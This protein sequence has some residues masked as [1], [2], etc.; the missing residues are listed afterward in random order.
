M[1]LFFSGRGSNLEAILTRYHQTWAKPPIVVTNNPEA[2]GI[3]VAR[4]FNIEPLILESPINYA[5]LSQYLRAEGVECIFLLGYLKII[6]S[7]FIKTWTNRIFNLHPSL[8][9]FYPGLRSI[10]R[11]YS[12]RNDIGVT[13][14][15][16]TEGVDE[17]QVMVQQMVISSKA[18][19]KDYIS[20]SQISSAYDGLSLEEIKL[21]VH[22]KEHQLVCD[23]IPMGEQQL[24]SEI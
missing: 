23:F 22:S 21:M 6:P 20:K 5:E 17:G 14:H 4:R 16:V 8:L 19:S 9:P 13:I 11:A 24:G 7:L 3:L 18:N 2:D 12:D 1:L 10:E 15:K